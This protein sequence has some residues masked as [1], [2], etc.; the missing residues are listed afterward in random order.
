M[1]CDRS[2]PGDYELD[3]VIEAAETDW[4]GV[5]EDE[6][7]FIVYGPNVRCIASRLDQGSDRVEVWHVISD[8]S[9][10]CQAFLDRLTTLQ[11]S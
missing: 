8:D 4:N 1:S 3:E 6:G 9:T 2:A 11:N 5:A 7:N 10:K